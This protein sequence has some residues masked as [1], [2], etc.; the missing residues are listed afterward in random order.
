MD[1]IKLKNIFSLNNVIQ[2]VRETPQFEKVFAIHIT[3]LKKKS[4]MYKKDPTNHKKKKDK[5]IEN[6]A[7]NLNRH[8]TKD[9]VQMIS[10]L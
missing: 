7:K 4:R 8:F 9:D 3:A 6:L 1:Y 5:L 10:N 2:K